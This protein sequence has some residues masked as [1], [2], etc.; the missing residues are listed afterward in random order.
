MA[1]HGL[2]DWL[3]QRILS[4]ATP[5]S[6]CHR[7]TVRGTGLAANLRARPYNAW[8]NLEPVP[9]PL[10]VKPAPESHGQVRG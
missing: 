1:A 2:S 5:S 6:Y 4:A 3:S 9:S 10:V 7:Q 8:R